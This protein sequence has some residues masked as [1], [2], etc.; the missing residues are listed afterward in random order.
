MKAMSIPRIPLALI[1]LLALA[2]GLW[3][4]CNST[5]TG[6]TR[7]NEYRAEGVLVQDMNVDHAFALVRAWRNDSTFTGGTLH[8]AGVPM[9]FFPDYQNVDSAYQAL[10]SPAAS[11]AG[12]EA[13]FRFADGSRFTDSLLVSIVDTFSITD[14]I[15][16]ANHQLQGAGQVSLEW[17]AA[18]NAEGYVVA[19][20]KADEAYTGVGYSAY[21]ATTGTAGTIPPEAFIDTVSFLPDTG[22]YN[23]Y[24]YALSGS[25]DSAL[26]YGFLPV[27]LPVQIAD[28]IDENDFSG[29]FGTLSVTLKDTIRVVTAR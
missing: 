4:G 1:G 27:P 28:N 8:L 2:F 13:Y 16:P 7:F 15:D 26:S 20:V 25:P 19:A 3:L 21:A 9:A 11:H 22:L 12:T 6:G 14:N 10:I 17:T 29:H 18:A 5:P 24:V 23:V